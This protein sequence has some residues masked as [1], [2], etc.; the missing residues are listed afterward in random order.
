MWQSTDTDCE[1]SVYEHTLA[2]DAL[3]KLLTSSLT[4]LGGSAAAN[5]TLILRSDNV[6]SE[7]EFNTLSPVYFGFVTMYMV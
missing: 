6:D 4:S 3:R 5:N 2:G 1:T 7:N